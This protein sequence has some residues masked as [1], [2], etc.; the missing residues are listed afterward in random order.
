MNITS[1]IFAIFFW[2]AVATIAAGFSLA[3][4]NTLR[5]PGGLIEIIFWAAPIVAI[6]APLFV[7]PL[8]GAMNFDADYCRD[9]AKT[10]SFT[11]IPAL[12]WA[13][14]LVLDAEPAWLWILYWG[15][16]IILAL[17]V[18]FVFIYV[19]KMSVRR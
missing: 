1:L 16:G 14:Y 11:L 18:A 4:G 7:L 2:S 15:E 10:A 17:L 9:T 3:S 6:L 5:L 8:L 13:G 12:V 19:R